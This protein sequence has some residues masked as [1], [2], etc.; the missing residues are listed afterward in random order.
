MHPALQLLAALLLSIVVEEFSSLII[1]LI[2][3]R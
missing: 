2:E 3:R 1:Y